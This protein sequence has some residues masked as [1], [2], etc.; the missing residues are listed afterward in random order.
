MQNEVYPDG[1][2]WLMTRNTD[3]ISWWELGERYRFRSWLC[4]D[5]AWVHWSRLNH[6]GRTT[7]WEK[8]GSRVKPHTT[9]TFEEQEVEP[10]KKKKKMN[11]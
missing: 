7:G 5:E 10:V 6:L 2:I 11:H 8:G 3:V 9:P 1:N 4:R